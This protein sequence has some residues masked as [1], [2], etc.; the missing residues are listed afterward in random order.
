MAVV[1][2]DIGARAP[3]E[4]GTPFGDA[5]P[6]ERLDGVLHVAVDPDH[7]ANAGIVDLDK[8]ARDGDGRVHFSADFCLLQPA[9]ADRGNRR[10][11]LDV[12]NRGRKLAPN[13]FNRATP[14]LEPTE[15][16][17]PGDG[18][19]MRHGWSVLWCGWQ[20][21]VVRSP[22]L[23]GLEAPRA[24]ENGQPI[25]GQVSVQFQ[26]NARTADHL[27]ADRVHQP[28]PAADVDDPDAVLSV[29]DWA[30]APRMEIPRARWRFARDE[31]GTPVPDD[32]RVWLEG[33]FEPGKV[34]QVVYRTRI[35]PV[36][37]AGLLATRD[38]ASFLRFADAAAGNPAAGRLDRA[39]AFGASQ[40]GRFLRHFLSLGLNMDE[41][42]RQVF[43]GINPHIAGARRGEFNH[44]YAQPS[45]QQ[46][47]SFGHLPP[48][49]DDDQT[50]PRTG[51]TDGLLR[52]QRGRGGVP[53]VIST[54]TG[55]E[56]WRGDTSLMHTD[57]AG[58]RDIEPPA[59]SR[60]YY[61]AGTQHGNGALPLTSVSL[62][63]GARGAHP[64]NAISYAPL[65]RAALVNLDRWVSAGEEPPPSVFPRLA[66]GT[67]VATAD[68]I[69]AFRAFPSATTP[70]PEKAP[71]IR[72]V[73][74][75]PNAERGVGRYPVVE[76]ERYRT[77]VSALD[78][79]G[80]EVGGVRLPDVSVP[81]ATYTGWN[82]RHPEV[83]GEGQILSM[84]GSTLPF[85]ATREQRARTG[86]PRPAIAERYRDR[87]DYLARVRAA[88]EALVAGRYLLAE[89]V[90]L[91]MQTAGQR[92]DA[93]APA[94]TPA[95][96][97]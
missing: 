95:G 31:A 13:Q 38:A 46:Q 83:G 52:R 49:A 77:H 14:V 32:T 12:L 66:E 51:R 21:D 2:I 45:D 59:E 94:L 27:L 50:D 24:I 37:G 11:L 47:R 7:P 89:D 16:I 56:Y 3:Y 18:F 36:V 53:R 74:L 96:T 29:R 80:N 65:L 19:L 78:A 87:E 25:S 55:A 42:G 90:D 17:D 91:V 67:A 20:W 63:D 58:E 22:A 84:M 76:G 9:D 26:P 10:L 54:N 39:Y 81:L 70:D 86:D 1:G 64:F 6:Y 40:S 62:V 97:P 34:Y 92:W 60:I 8:A 82:P 85:P 68:V 93:F 73:D 61:F 69:A 30:D 41:A 15:R 88:A 75:G 5:G 35:C 72:A 48:F 33:G 23:M 71:V 79:D 57:L 4:D 28:Y 44:R 43:D